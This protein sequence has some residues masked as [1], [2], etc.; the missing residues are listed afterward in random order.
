VR[1]LAATAD[2]ALAKLAASGNQES[3]NNIADI[4]KR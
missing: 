4:N 1:Q 2:K 3:F